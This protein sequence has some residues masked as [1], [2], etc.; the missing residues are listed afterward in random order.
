MNES[1]EFLGGSEVTGVYGKT[2]SLTPPELDGYMAP[3][4]QTVAWDS[5]EQKTIRF[6]YSPIIN[7]TY[8]VV[9]SSV[10]GTYLGS[11]TVTYPYG[12]TVTLFAPEIAGY[13]TPD[14]MT[15][16]WDTT[17]RKTIQFL[18]SPAYVGYTVRS[19]Y[20]SNS[21][22]YQLGYYATVEYQ[23][24]TANSVELRVIMTSTLS[25][26]EAYNAYGQRF[27]ANVGSAGTG[28]VYINGYGTWRNASSNSR[29]D[30]GVSGW[31]TVPLGTTNATSVDM[32]VYYY[33]V[34]SNGTDM[35]QYYGVDGMSGTWTVSIPAY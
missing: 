20:V 12:T 5:T 26:L 23:N 3:P 17:D 29:S 9:Y 18:Y 22:Y 35:T 8:D 10:N 33:Q 6:V 2:Y 4:A 19:G 16:V 27:S 1:G 7:C 31:F 14:S 25:G 24:R 13:Q 21:Q 11:E 30:T 28:S 32:S 34:N 15:V